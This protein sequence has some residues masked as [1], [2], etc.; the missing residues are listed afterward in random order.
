MGMAA[1]AGTFPK[2]NRIVSALCTAVVV[3]EAPMRSGAL[4]T[5]RITRDLGRTLFAV[6]GEVAAGRSSGCHGLIRRGEAGLVE[7]AADVLESL[8]LAAP[9]HPESRPRRPPADDGSPEGM[10]AALLEETRNVDELSELSG[11]GPARTLDLLL[12]ME[13]AGKVVQLPGKR[14]CRP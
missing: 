10:V 6:P 11:L 5:A 13:M 1:A 8:G 9:R 12:R 14:F 4:I 7:R 2:R 3:A